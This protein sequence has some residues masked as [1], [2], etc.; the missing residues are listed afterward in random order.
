MDWIYLSPHPDDVALSCG[1]LV[2]EQVQAG[3]AVSIW[4]I[5]AEDPPAGPL[6]PF[7]ASL[8]TRWDT[9]S[10]AMEQRRAEDIA[11]CA[12][13]EATHRH[14]PIPD[15]IY[16]R[17]EGEFLYASEAA[18]F[19]PLHPKEAS[20]VERLSEELDRTVTRET[21]LV[22]PLALGDHVDHRLTRAAAE[23]LQRPL[24]YYA[25]YPYVLR[26]S[27][28]IEKLQREG[29]TA[30]AFKVSDPGLRAW[31]ASIAAHKSQI[32]TFWPDLEAMHAAIRAYHCQ[33]DG[34]VRLWQSPT[35][36]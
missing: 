33:N 14:F 17:A 35:V 6:S 22:C 24:W 16:R 23:H 28:Q 5:C 1:G 12:L 9:G 11:S 29:W 34:G 20:Q 13:L 27:G 36:F 2:W 21:N 15:C 25:D 7:A 19:N 26:V 8:H 10:A 18:L 30:I 3:N 4:T 31:E 32:S